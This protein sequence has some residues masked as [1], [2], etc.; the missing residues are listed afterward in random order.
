VRPRLASG[1]TR[2]R[3]GI[4]TWRRGRV[5]VVL[6]LV[7]LGGCSGLT[8]VA[9]PDTTQPGAFQNPAGALTRSAGAVAQFYN[10][11]SQL[12]FNSGELTDEL[13]YLGLQFVNLDHRV[14]PDPAGGAQ[15]SPSGTEVGPQTRVNA[16]SA[17]ALLQQYNPTPPARI[18][19]LFAV[20]GTI[21]TVLAEDM[22]AGVPLATVVNGVPVVGS[23]TT[24]VQLYAHALAQ[25][26][27][28]AH[29][30]A[31]SARILNWVAVGRG[32][33]LLDLDSVAAAA[34][35]VS[36][37]P[38][39]YSYQ[40]QYTATTTQ[41]NLIAQQMINRGLAVSD[42]EGLNGL[43]F[44]SAKDPRVP[45]DS[46]GIGDDGVTPDYTFRPYASY[47]APM[48]VASGIEARLIEA[49]AA[50]AGGD[51]PTW[52]SA[53]NNL[54][55]DSAETGITGLRPLT[56]DSTTLATHATQVDVMFRERAFWLFATGHRQ[57]DLRRLIRQYGRAQAQV[58]P[59][60]PYKNTGQQYGTDV[61]IPV[62][63]ENVNPSIRDCLN[64]DA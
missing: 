43:D 41:Q 36:G 19:E 15:A 61:T 17:I 18:G 29:Y 16:L 40:A 12:A 46:I 44:V 21:E 2:R 59:T 20:L 58:F 32:R 56:A 9:A 1:R 11:M 53:L 6:S 8:K 39:G 60:G 42:R 47:G 24:S 26:D 37:V 5:T 48:T 30:A 51:V 34:R 28:A 13:I 27:S 54:R 4:V 64:R 31:D 10:D 23:P 62:T 3:A 55:A 22:C 25:F 57:G 7:G 14:L 49:E 38:T 35:A 63:G 45:T 52:T 33:A 50:L